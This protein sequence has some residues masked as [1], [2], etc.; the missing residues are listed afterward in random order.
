MFVLFGAAAAFVIVSINILKLF[1]RFMRNSY[2]NEHR[3]KTRIAHKFHG[4]NIEFVAQQ[5]H[6]HTQEQGKKI[7][8]QRRSVTEQNPHNDQLYFQTKSHLNDTHFLYRVIDAIQFQKFHFSSSSVAVVVVVVII[9]LLIE[10]TEIFFFHTHNIKLLE[11]SHG[12]QCVYC[13]PFYTRVHC[14]SCNQIKLLYISQNE[15]IQ[16]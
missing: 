8:T 2:D 11:N 6:A 12:D 10:C 14:C 4:R 7:T 1:K 5:Q 16:T 15:Q 3:K 13:T 9:L